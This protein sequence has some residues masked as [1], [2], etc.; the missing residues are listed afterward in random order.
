MKNNPSNINEREPRFP[1]GEPGALRSQTSI[2]IQT[3]R[4]QA[5]VYG[6][7]AGESKHEIVGLLRFASML[8]PVWA[9]CSNDDPFA[10][11]RLVQVE[12][13]LE[14]SREHVQS[15]LAR[16]TENLRHVPAS[17]AVAQ[18]LAPVRVELAF[19]CPYAFHGA[20]LLMEYDTLVRAILT[21]RHVGLMDRKTAEKLLA[22]GARAVRGAYE[23]ARGYRYHA[24]A[25]NDVRQGTA[26]ALKAREVM[27]DL[28]QPVIAGELRATLAPEIRSQGQD[29]SDFDEQ[30]TELA[31]DEPE[32]DSK[33]RLTTVLR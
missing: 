25:R 15:L 3:R 2:E 29:S 21:A 12:R 18:S 28:P 32:V 20:Y 16:V 13:T 1:G 14:A 33:D 27:G 4:A 9:G 30:Q 24:I 11:W 6:R 17:V 19:T 26:R 5:L 10:D 7:P 8:R 23:S 31:D 22:D